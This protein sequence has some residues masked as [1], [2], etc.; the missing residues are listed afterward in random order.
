[1]LTQ[2]AAEEVCVRG[3]CK[4]PCDFKGTLK[5]DGA[6]T[7]VNVVNPLIEECYEAYAVEIT[8]ARSG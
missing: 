1:L 5:I 4:T 6:T 3:T 2:V 7:N 8:D